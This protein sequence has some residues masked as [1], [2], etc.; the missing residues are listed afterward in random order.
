MG[1][2]FG[3]WL[4][5][6]NATKILPKIFQVNW[7]RK[8]P[9]GRFLWPGYGENMRVLKWVVDR[10]RGRSGALETPIGWVPK[11]SDL[12]L[13][14]MAVPLED[15]DAAEAIEPKEWLD[16]LKDQ[17]EFFAK[18][19]ATMPREL[20]LQRELLMARLVRMT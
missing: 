4:D 11:Q 17:E 19:A 5:M 6:A 1:Q 9:D 3:H 10:A 18:L 14:G 15:V 8:G 12:D 20:V 13:S 16:E 7:F 2:Y